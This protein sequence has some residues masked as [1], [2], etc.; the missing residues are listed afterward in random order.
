[1]TG[2]LIRVIGE[3][4]ASDIKAAIL[5]AL[6]NLLLKIPQFLR[7]FI[8]QLQRTFVRSLSDNNEKLRKRAVVAL[9]TL[10]KFQPRVDSL[11]TELVN[12]IKTT[13]FKESMLKAMLVV[14]EQAGKSLSE[15]S[16]QSILAVAEQE[17]DPILIGSLAGSLSDEEASN[18]LKSILSDEE[19]KFSILAINSFLKYSPEHVKNDQVVEYLKNCA[20]SSNAYMSDN[21]TIAIGKM[22]LLSEG[23]NTD[24]NTA[25]LIEQLAINIVQPKSSSPDTRRL[26]LV[27]VRTFARKHQEQLTNE[28]FD[29]IVPSIFSSIRDPIIPIKLAAEKAFLE[30]FNM[31]EKGNEVF[32]SWFKGE[33]LITV[34]GTTIVARSIGDYTKRVATR[35]A[36][37]ERERIEAGGDEE[38]LFSDRI[39]DENEIWQ[40]GI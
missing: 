1:M 16:K 15:A 6:N 39:E 32:D 38:T 35:L 36:N 30:V 11:V 27:V 10:I 24:V 8:P 34:T 25:E 18:I 14:V 7:P 20:N 29:V 12:G 13:E 33:N 9:G 26:S 37:V 19:S 5:V 31:V 28:V 22:L 40:V 2:P 4:V 23:E 3:K 21:A 17:M